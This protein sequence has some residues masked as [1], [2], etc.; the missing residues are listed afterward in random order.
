[1]MRNLI[2]YKDYLLS[3]YLFTNKEEYKKKYEE[4]NKILE[5]GVGSKWT[6]KNFIKV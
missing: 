1:M 4:I 5:K 3:V 6:K 2:E